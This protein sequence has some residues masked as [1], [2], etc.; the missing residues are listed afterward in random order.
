MTRSKGGQI[1]ARKLTKSDE[2]Y[3]LLRRKKK[4]KLD[5]W[6]QVKWKTADGRRVKLTAM[7]NGHPF[8]VVINRV[9]LQRGS[10][11]TEWNADGS[12]PSGIKEL[13]LVRIRR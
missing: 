8:G 6:A 4:V 3:G 1:A 5:D 12:H 10:F 13:D 7:V 9:Y 11:F 2:N